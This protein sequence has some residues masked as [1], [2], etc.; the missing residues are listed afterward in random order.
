[1][2]LPA[3]ILVWNTLKTLIS[4]LSCRLALGWF[5]TNF[6]ESLSGGLMASH[7]PRGYH[8]S[9][10]GGY[11]TLLTLQ[12]ASPNSQSLTF[13]DPQ[14]IYRLQGGPGCWS[15]DLWKLC[16]QSHFC[17][18]QSWAEGRRIRVS[19]QSAKAW[20]S[21]PKEMWVM[22]QLGPQPQDTMLLS[23]HEG[24]LQPLDHGAS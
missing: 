10:A 1:M 15:P 23:L 22:T 13:L 18:P 16:T 3:L 9:L 4:A 6:S 5:I 2:E 12:P 20:A 7:R 8:V 19:K 17:S 21:P 11:Q 14:E 24:R